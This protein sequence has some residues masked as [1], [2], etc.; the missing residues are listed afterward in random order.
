MPGSVLSLRQVRHKTWETV[1]ILSLLSEYGQAND[2]SFLRSFHLFPRS[3]FCGSDESRVV[4]Q[5]SEQY[6]KHIPR[7]RHEERA[8]GREAG[9]PREMDFDSLGRRSS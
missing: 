5:A 3:F 9:S 7:H 6:L 4:S 1:A 8:A 2:E